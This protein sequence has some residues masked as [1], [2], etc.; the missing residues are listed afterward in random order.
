[1]GFID[2]TGTIIIQPKYDY[3][4]DFYNLKNGKEGMAQVQLNGM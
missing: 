2:K 3:V 1:M 4:N